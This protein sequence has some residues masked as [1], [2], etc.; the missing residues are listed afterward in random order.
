MYSVFEGTIGRNTIYPVIVFDNN[1]QRVTGLTHNEVNVVYAPEGSG[2]SV[3]ELT[4]D[5]WLEI[6]LGGYWLVFGRQE[7]DESR[8]Y[9]INVGGQGL[10]SWTFFVQAV[11]TPM[12]EFQQPNV[13]MA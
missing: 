5:D 3:K 13:Q 2:Y 12:K 7:F 9:M 1:G 8:I 6:G 10:A 4:A 11:P